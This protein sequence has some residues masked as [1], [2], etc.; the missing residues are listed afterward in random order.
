MHSVSAT[1]MLPLAV[2]ITAVSVFASTTFA[3]TPAPTSADVVAGKPKV[4]A[5]VSAVGDTLTYIRQKRKVGSNIID[6]HSR[7]TM[8]VPGNALNAAVLRG[9]ESAV[10]ELEP[11]ATR[12]TYT[13]AATE[14]E[15]VL[16]Q[17]R[18]AVAIGKIAT[19]L[20]KM[21]ERAGWDIIVAAVP[22]YQFTGQN[23]IGDKI[24]GLGFYVQPLASGDIS[25][26]LGGA[27]VDLESQ[28]A[29][30]TQSP[31]L[32]KHRS[33]RFVAPFAYLAVY[34]IDAKTMRVI[35][36]KIRKDHRKLFDPMATA[37][38]VAAS[39]PPEVLAGRLE[40]IT[41]RAAALAA[42][43]KE[44]PPGVNVGPVKQVNP[45]PRNP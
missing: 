8:K 26:L 16:P 6:N 9:L 18:E 20:D 35:D 23:H 13:L 10:A 3:Q 27:S 17:D 38:D 19:A 22:A 7:N 33:K 14:M 43:A 11:G 25:D 5:L 1:V 12:L 2:F 42:G 30:D 34:T 4:Y 21:P 37:I 36:K 44:T 24:Q 41:E 31:E 28:G 15:G 40:S 39:I 45:P 29:P 32:E